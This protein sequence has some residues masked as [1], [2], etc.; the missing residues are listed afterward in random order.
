MKL[1]SPG[2][3]VVPEDP[4]FQGERAPIPGCRKVKDER[5]FPFYIIVQH[6]VVPIDHGLAD[7]QA[8]PL[9]REVDQNPRYLPG[10]RSFFGDAIDVELNIDGGG[11]SIF[12]STFRERL[13]F[14]RNFSSGGF[15]STL[16]ARDQI[17]K[18]VKKVGEKRYY[19]GKIPRREGS[20]PGGK[21]DWEWTKKPDLA[22]LSI[23]LSPFP[24]FFPFFT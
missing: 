23:F 16:P 20:F 24:F 9:D 5:R 1:G 3:T 12:T 13:F 2:N 19:T 4:G 15:L 21:N 14:I 22:S 11:L 18:V 7:L 6:E 8:G 17:V 10:E